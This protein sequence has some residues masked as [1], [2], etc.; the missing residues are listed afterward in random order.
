M[1]WH[2]YSGLR[3]SEGDARIHLPSLR[4]TSPHPCPPAKKFWRRSEH[5][6][7]SRGLLPGGFAAA[8][9]RFLSSNLGRPYLPYPWS[10]APAVFSSEVGN[11]SPSPPQGADPCLEFDFS[12]GSWTR[13]LAAASPRVREGG[14]STEAAGDDG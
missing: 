5:F 3:C 9:P 11:M 2:I 13:G 14:E 1:I 4:H 8:S 7:F 12:R 6:F 10:E